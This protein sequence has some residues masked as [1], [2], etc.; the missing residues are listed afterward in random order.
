MKNIRKLSDARVKIL[1]GL[2]EDTPERALIVALAREVMEY[3]LTNQAA[4]EKMVAERLFPKEVLY[5][6]EMERH[7]ERIRELRTR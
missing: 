7:A 2:P 4:A 3:R 1:T 6:L 5:D